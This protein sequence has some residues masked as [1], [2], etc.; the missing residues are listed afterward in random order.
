LDGKSIGIVVG[1][2]AFMGM[3]VSGIYFILLQKFAGKMIKASLIFSIAIT[4]A[5]S[6][7]FF[8][9]GQVFP[10]V[11]WLLFA[12]LYAWCFW[13]WRF[14]IVSV[15]KLNPSHL[16]KLCSKLSP[17]LLLDTLL[18]LLLVSSVF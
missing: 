13:S 16:L 17:L 1:L 15:N 6:L 2:S 11:L 5:A 12:A 3:V 10:G 7:F 18:S 4:L 8:F 9:L 14:R